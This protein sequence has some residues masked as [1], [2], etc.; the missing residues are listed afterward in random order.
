M[1]TNIKWFKK[2]K[3]IF[4]ENKKKDTKKFFLLSK[5]LENVY[6]YISNSTT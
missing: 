4:V 2:V 6:K 3:C 5:I 1:L